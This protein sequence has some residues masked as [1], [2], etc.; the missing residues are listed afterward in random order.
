MD[1]CCGNPSEAAGPVVEID[2][3]IRIGSASAVLANNA[4]TVAAAKRSANGLPVMEIPLILAACGP[5][6]VTGCV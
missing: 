3:P 4:K 2:T 5:R 1:F 6:I